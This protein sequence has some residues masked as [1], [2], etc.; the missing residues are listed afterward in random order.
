MRFDK[1]DLHFLLVSSRSVLHEIH[2]T[3]DRSVLLAGVFDGHGGTA[4]STMAAETLP[5]LVSQE[6]LFNTSIPSVEDV[7]VSAWETVGEAYRLTCS[8]SDTCSADY[9]PKEGTLNANTG[10]EDLI[11]GTTASIFGLDET[12]GSLTFMN[13]G[14]SRSILIDNSGKVVFETSDHTLQAEQQRFLQGV[15]AGLNYSVPECF[16]SRWWLP[17]GEYEYALGRSLEGPFATSK[18]IISVPDVVTLK[19]EPGMIIVSASDGLYDVMDSE[20]VAHYLARARDVSKMT[21]SDAAKTLSNRALEKGTPDNVSVV[22][23][24]L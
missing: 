8:D 14:D 5:S 16:L 22:V 11:A 3:R 15:E 13:C 23:V 17:V 7:L 10:S 6:L 24:Y 20:E 2:D 19:A 18:G 1:T 12:T 9:D 21:A 4:A